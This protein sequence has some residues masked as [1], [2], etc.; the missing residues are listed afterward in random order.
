MA[1]TQAD[2]DELKSAIA[3][4]ARTVRYTDNSEVT[5]RSLAEMKS[6][7][8]DMQAEVDKAAGSKRYKAFR[9]ASGNGGY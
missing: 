9:L 1:F 8:G 3:S 7:L 2:V 4:G 6:I 5:Y